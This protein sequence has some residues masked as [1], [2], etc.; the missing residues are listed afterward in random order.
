M[1]INIAA[2]Y[3]RLSKNAAEDLI[4][5]VG[6]KNNPLICVASGDSPAGL[7]REVVKKVKGHE[8]N[9]QA[10]NFLGL[11]EWVGLNGADEGSC[12]FHLDNQ[13]FKPL[14]MSPDKILFVDGR[15]DDP[16]QQCEMVERFIQKQGG[17]D[18]AVVGLGMNGHIGMNE[19]G[20]SV[21]QRTHI[22]RLDPLTVQVG[23]KYFQKAQPLSAGITLGLGTLMEAKY[24]LL[25]VNGAK[26]A[27]IVKQVL[28]GPITENIPGSLFRNH[29]GFIVY[30]DKEAAS[31]LSNEGEGDRSTMGK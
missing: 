8:V 25:L 4:S 11:D 7:Y 1:I 6:R 12:R 16:S 10:W 26:K 15:S 31:M 9:V 3:E 28:E 29:P 27:S 21:S 2:D 17:I 24:V 14:Q 19:P 30:L 13:F 18:V 23:Q 20:T 5:M 22:A